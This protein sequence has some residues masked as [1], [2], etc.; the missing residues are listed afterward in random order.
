METKICKKCGLEKEL[1]EY[2]KD[3]YSSDGYRYR[4]RSCTSE[5]YKN[6]YYSNK[7]EEIKRQIKYQHSNI[8]N[9][10]YKRRERHCK[11]YKTDILYKIKVNVRNRIKSVIYAKNLNLNVGDTYKILGCSPLEFKQYLENKFLDGMNWE[12]YKLDG[13]HIDHIIPL[14]T[15]KSVEDVYKLCHYTSLQPLWCYQNYKKSNKINTDEFTGN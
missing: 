5:E 6:F 12:N 11:K 9:V 1:T 14:S 7:T 2:N 4:C 8:E 13:W 10:K 15:A 3:K